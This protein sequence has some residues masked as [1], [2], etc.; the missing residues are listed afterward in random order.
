YAMVHQCQCLEL[1][2]VPGLTLLHR[3]VPYY[4]DHWRPVAGLFPPEAE[5]ALRSIPAPGAD[6]SADAE[7][8]I[9]FP[10]R[11]TS[12]K[13]RRTCVFATTEY[14][15][16]PEPYHPPGRPLAAELAES[17]VMVVT[18]SHW[19]REGFLRDGIDPSRVVVVPHG[20]D[21]AILRPLAEAER[22]E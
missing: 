22:A 12:S 15:C 3:D 16:V 13:Q 14:R 21:P 9:F 8:R 6:E 11:W 20:A 18:P 17:D 7:L 1:L 19:S 4:H 2:R 5:E 10:P